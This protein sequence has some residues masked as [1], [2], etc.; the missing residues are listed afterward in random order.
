MFF[1]LTVHELY[2]FTANILLWRLFYV[3]WNQQQF[4]YEHNLSILLIPEQ[5]S[6]S[7]AIVAV[8]GSALFMINL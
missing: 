5:R 4:I 1:E 7:A 3:H 2:N 8:P 6:S